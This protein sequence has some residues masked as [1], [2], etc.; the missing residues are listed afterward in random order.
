MAKAYHS[1][2]KETSNG[3]KF[4]FGFVSSPSTYILME[5]GIKVNEGIN[6]D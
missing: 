2:S 3:D 6:Q 4:R 1:L 5:T